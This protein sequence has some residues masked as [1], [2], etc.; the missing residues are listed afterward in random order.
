MKELHERLANFAMNNSIQ[1]KGPLCV[2]LLITHKAMQSKFPLYESSFLAPNE[3]QVSGLSRSSIQSILKDYNIT[4]V[5]AEEGG[6][7]SRGSIGRMKN[8][9]L[10]LNSLFSDGILDLKEIEHWWIQRINDHFAAKPFKLK[11]DASKSL[12]SII[13]DL[14]SNANDRQRKFPGTMII[15]AIL[16]HLVGAKL[17]IALPN[18]II[19][20]YGFSVA[21]NPTDRKGD[22]LINDTAIH[23][24]TSPSESLIRKCINNLSINLR[25]IIITTQKGAA[26][27]AILAENENVADRIEILEIEQFITTNILEQSGFHQHERPITVAKLIEVYNCIIDHCET[28]PSL[29]IEIG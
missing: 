17:E 1:G 13:T 19:A 25:P 12:R 11:V 20:H 23:V 27:A 18:Y 15:G 8:Y 21:D 16:Q 26:G 24:T 22:F 2:V 10:F 4:R 14:I 3:G 28:D 29:H 5:L 9:I 6:R 7:T